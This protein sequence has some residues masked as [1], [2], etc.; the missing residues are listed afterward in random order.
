MV[1]L[2]L[3]LIGDYLTQSDWMARQKTSDWWAAFCH[4]T[5]YAAPFFL[6]GDL[7]AVLVIQWTHFFIDRF[8]LARYLVFAKNYMLSPLRED[9]KWADCK[10]TGYPNTT[11][12]WLA[13]WLLI[14]ADNTLHMLINYAALRWLK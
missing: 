4:A 7:R 5:I 9:I 11:P 14:I 10:L 13:T 6:V 2:L 12:V 8:R 1:Q 3:H